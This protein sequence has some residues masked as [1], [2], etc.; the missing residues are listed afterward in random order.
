M[1][2]KDF[3]LILKRLLEDRL[4]LLN[5]LI[6]E[7]ILQINSVYSF[8]NLLRCAETPTHFIGELLGAKQ[9]NSTDK[10]AV[11]LMQNKIEKISS[12]N[13]YF[14]PY[15]ENISQPV[16]H[17]CADGCTLQ[18]ILLVTN[19]NYLAL[20]KIKFP[21]PLVQITNKQGDFPLKINDD[22][23]LLVLKDMTLIKI[24]DFIFYYRYIPFSIIVKKN[25]S[26]QELENRLG[27]DFQLE[28]SSIKN[29]I[30]LSYVSGINFSY[31]NS[32]VYFANQLIS[33]SNQIIKELLIDKF[34]EEHKSILANSWGYKDVLKV[35]FKWIERDKS[36][37]FESRPDFILVK[38]DSTF[39]ILDLKTGAIQFRSLIKKKKLK[40][41]T[42]IRIRFIDYVNELISQLEEYKNCF[43]YIKNIQHIKNYGLD[44]DL[45][46]M[47]LIGVVGNQNNF[48]SIEVNSAL[49]PFKDYIKIISYF[50]LANMA[51]KIKM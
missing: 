39:D 10:I 28:I 1:N 44:V 16:L 5:N 36:E 33:M 42:Q 7:K 50:D 49:S 48:D 41:S 47:K 51:L 2:V 31:S 38:E 40:N 29:N 24:L 11:K 32:N 30:N 34:I 18:S 8:N 13:S 27:T 4:N 45:S 21:L 23:H 3:S 37:P 20:Q 15:S 14:I 6:N 12:T 22:V 35:T 46:N 17:M 25:I 9:Y 26:E 43:K 19:E